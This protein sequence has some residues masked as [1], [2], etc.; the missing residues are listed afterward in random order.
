MIDPLD[1]SLPSRLARRLG[2]PLPGRLA[3]RQLA[4]EL[5]YGRHAGPAASDARPAAVLA[6]LYPEAGGWRIPLTLRPAHMIDHAR[7]VSF[8]GGM[9]EPGET[10]EKCAL[11]EY[12]E[13]LGACADRLVVLGR[14][15]PL[16]VFASNFMVIPCV[17]VAA[18][19]PVLD[20]NPQ[21]VERVL[22]LPLDVLLDSHQRGEHVLSRRGF[23]FAT[24]HVC[25]GED[26]IWGAT[27]MMLAELANVIAES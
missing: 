22:D 27:G 12:E 15:T 3:H 16:Y 21:E 24:Q 19:P 17:A 18:T 5:A 26:L 23:S 2:E 10:A 14:L 20:P 9:N 13:E 11:R 4:S 7:Q 8:P 25:C 1:D 6:C